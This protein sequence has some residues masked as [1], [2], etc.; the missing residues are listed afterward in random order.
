MVADVVNAALEITER[1]GRL[2]TAVERL[3]RREL[4]PLEQLDFATPALALRFPRSLRL[5]DTTG[6]SPGRPSGEDVG[7]MPGGCSCD[8]ITAH[9]S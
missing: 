1:F 4:D 3:E 8:T 5:G 7:T 6:E 9:G 2:A